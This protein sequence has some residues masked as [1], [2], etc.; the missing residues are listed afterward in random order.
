[1]DGMEGLSDRGRAGHG[2]AGPGGTATA[3][4]IPA[5]DHEASPYSR[6]DLYDLLFQGYTADLGFY[7]EAARAANGPVVAEHQGSIV[8]SAWRD[9]GG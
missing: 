7:L 1:M 2:I 6:A 9:A 8:V 5:M 3:A 4:G